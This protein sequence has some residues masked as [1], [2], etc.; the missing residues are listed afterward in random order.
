MVTRCLLSGGDVARNSHW[1]SSMD[2]KQMQGHQPP[3]PLDG[4]HGHLWCP[5]QV[6]GSTQPQEHR[7]PTDLGNQKAPAQPQKVGHLRSRRQRRLRRLALPDARRLSR[8][9]NLAPTDIA[10]QILPRRLKVRKPL[11][12][13][14]TNMK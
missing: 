3:W 8:Q 2:V 4:R 6:L 1:L 13:T 10:A 5:N 7:C 9:K 11:T 14:I 12:L